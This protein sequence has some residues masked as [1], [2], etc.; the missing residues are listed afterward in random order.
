MAIDAVKNSAATNNTTAEVL[1]NL[2]GISKTTTRQKTTQL[3]QC[4]TLWL[5]EVWSLHSSTVNAAVDRPARQT[6]T[7]PPDDKNLQ[8][9]CLCVVGDIATV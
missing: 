2:Y 5:S 6:A 3:N 8:K 9:N 4:V 7:I 1:V